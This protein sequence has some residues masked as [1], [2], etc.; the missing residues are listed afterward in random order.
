MLT[1][2]ID[3]SKIDEVTVTLSGIFG[4]ETIITK[5]KNV[6]GSQVILSAIEQILANKEKS[7]QD[8]TAINVYEEKGS[9][10]G[11]RVGASIAN[12]L[13]YTLKIPING[14]VGVFVYPQYE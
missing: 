4:E 2:Y 5:T 3:S 13:S 6:R 12:A 8:I 14:K 1:L 9:Y 10:T 11:R 7:L